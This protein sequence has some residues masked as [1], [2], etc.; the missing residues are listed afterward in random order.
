MPPP[1]AC[2]FRSSPPYFASDKPH[3]LIAAAITLLAACRLPMLPTVIIAVA[4]SGLL[5]LLMN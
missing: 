5:G 3:E 2:W 4:S 1:A